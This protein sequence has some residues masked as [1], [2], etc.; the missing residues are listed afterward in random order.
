MSANRP[1][2]PWPSGSI[3]TS[4]HLYLIDR[5]CPFLNCSQGWG[6]LARSVPANAQMT[7]SHQGIELQW[8]AEEGARC[9]QRIALHGAAS[10]MDLLSY[11]QLRIRGQATGQVVV[12]LEDVSGGRQKTT[13]P[14]RRS[15]DRSTSPFH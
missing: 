14:W 15:P 2:L 6:R 10:P 9:G 11:E 8:V 3:L 1:R 4:C 13:C 12:A 7:G 5:L